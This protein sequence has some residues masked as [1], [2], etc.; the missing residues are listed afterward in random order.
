[1]DI[2]FGEWKRKSEVRVRFTSLGNL[3]LGWNL[4]FGIFEEIRSLDGSHFL[5]NP[6]S[7]I[8]NPLHQPIYRFPKTKIAALPFK[9]LPVVLYLNWILWMAFPSYESSMSR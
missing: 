9:I 5:R 3:E 1:M 7:D 8:R 6:K 2:W 4:I